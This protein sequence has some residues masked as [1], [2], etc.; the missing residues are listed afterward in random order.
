[1]ADGDLERVLQLNADHV[2][3]LSEL[4]RERLVRLRAWASR[5]DVVV[6]DGEVAGFV[7]VFSPGT[8]YDSPNYRWFTDAYG[9]DFDYLDRIV[10]DDRFRR[11]GLAG[12]VYDEV[13][14]TAA[15]RGRLTLEVNLDPPNEPSLAFHR[16]RGYQE[17]A[18][19]GTSGH[20][21][22]LMAKEL[23]GRGILG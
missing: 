8:P 22:S 20:I 11:R 10:I 7:L 14:A 2:E 17:V 16:R 1:M 9:P 3:L 13:E 21:V 6:C 12:A 15:P 19:L 23:Y 18:Q 4:D 5:A